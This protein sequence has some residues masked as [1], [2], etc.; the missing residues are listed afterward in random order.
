MFAIV[1]SSMEPG[2]KGGGEENDRA[3]AILLNIGREGRG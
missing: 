3:S 2:E 1:D